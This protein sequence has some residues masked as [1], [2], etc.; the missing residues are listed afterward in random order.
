M[1]S[2]STY[3]SRVSLISVDPAVASHITGTTRATTAPTTSQ[4]GSSPRKSTKTPDT[5][6]SRRH[7]RNQSAPNPTGKKRSNSLRRVKNSTEVLRLRSK[8]ASKKGKVP[9]EGQD[10]REGRNFTVGN[11]GTGGVLYL[12]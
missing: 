11:V 2:E 1:V 5:E 4:N 10:T 8:K 6:V 9:D 12:T 7:I 3:S